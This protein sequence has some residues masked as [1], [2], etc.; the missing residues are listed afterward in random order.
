MDIWI[1]M[2]KKK[3]FRRCVMHSFIFWGNEEHRENMAYKIYMWAMKYKTCLSDGWSGT[4]LFT[5]YKLVVLSIKIWVFEWGWLIG[6]II[7]LINWD[8]PISSMRFSHNY[9]N[10]DYDLRFT[11]ISFY[12][13]SS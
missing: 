13:I 1:G 7:T 10:D 3:E 8:P 5:F 12:G 6:E 4:I 9:E 11:P 2:R